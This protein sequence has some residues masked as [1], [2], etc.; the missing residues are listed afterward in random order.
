MSAA[1]IAARQPAVATVA[2]TTPGRLRIRLQMPRGQGK[3]HQVA[4]EL[5]AVPGT[6]TVRAN[7]TARSVTVTYDPH[8]VSASALLDR[9]CRLGVVALDLADPMEWAETLAEEVVPEAENPTSLPGR[10]NR[11]LL[12]AT[13]GKVDLFRITVALLLLTAGYQVRVSL[14][15]GNGVP[16]LRVLTYLLAA[17]SIWTRRQ[18]AEA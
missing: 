13:A 5:D 17:A 10:L 8:Q 12:L 7:H 1:G 15:R 4:S 9:L 11:Q 14:L 6:E 16:W 18:T 2:H 3:L